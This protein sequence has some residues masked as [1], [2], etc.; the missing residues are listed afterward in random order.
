MGGSVTIRSLERGLKVLRALQDRPITSLH[1][2]YRQTGISKPSLLRILQT[3][4]QSGLVSRRLADGYYRICSNL[5]HLAR[6]TDGSIA[7]QS[8]AVCVPAVMRS[9]RMPW[10][11]YWIHESWRRRLKLKRDS[12]GSAPASRGFRY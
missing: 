4:E 5:T 3:L 9:D 11:S 10:A 2:I 6:A 12:E 1:D 8:M 7:A